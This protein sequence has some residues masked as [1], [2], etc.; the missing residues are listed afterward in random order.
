M[1]ESPGLKN[2]FSQGTEGISVAGDAEQSLINVPVNEDWTMA[3]I[4]TDITA[5]VVTGNKVWDEG[6]KEFRARLK[7]YGRAG[8]PPDSSVQVGETVLF[9]RVGEFANSGDQGFE[10]HT[11]DAQKTS[12]ICFVRNKTIFIQDMGGETRQ[13][14][15]VYYDELRNLIVPPGSETLDLVAADPLSFFH[16]S[17]PPFASGRIYWGQRIAGNNPYYLVFLPGH[18]DDGKEFSYTVNSVTYTLTVDGQG[19]IKDLTIT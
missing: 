7:Y 9:R 13:G 11:E 3:V 17:S 6:T 5:G 14:R 1:S 12:W 15:E 19:N 10:L 16:E 8:V 2:A 4:V 18:G